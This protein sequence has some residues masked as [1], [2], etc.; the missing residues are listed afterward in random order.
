MPEPGPQHQ[1]ALVRGITHEL[2]DT[3]GLPREVLPVPPEEVYAHRGRNARE[4]RRC[5]LHYLYDWAR[6]HREV[7]R[8]H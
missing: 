6:E 5:V 1:A 4:L 8:M 3:W 2:A 7:G